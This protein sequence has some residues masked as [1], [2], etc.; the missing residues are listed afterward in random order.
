[1]SVVSI[2]CW[3]KNDL[4]E[5]FG[6]VCEMVMEDLKTGGLITHIDDVVPYAVPLYD[7]ANV[8]DID[9]WWR[10]DDHLARWIDDLNKLK[11]Q[12]PNAMDDNIQAGIQQL[13]K[14]K[15]LYNELLHIDIDDGHMML[16]YIPHIVEYSPLLN[17][18]HSYQALSDFVK[19][20]TLFFHNLCNKALQTIN[21]G[22]GYLFIQCPIIFYL[23]G[24]LRKI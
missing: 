15:R 8:P 22:W 7:E 3:N 20:Y 16:K 9:R 6:T 19:K 23:Y 5:R 21:V 17:D 10:E 13:S 24:G 2:Q 4:S 1:M 18:N 11:A 12:T 14:N